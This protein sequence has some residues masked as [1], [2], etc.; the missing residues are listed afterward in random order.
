VNAHRLGVEEGE[1]QFGGALQ[2]HRR[3]TG[4][5]GEGQHA[6]G[7]ITRAVT[8]IGQRTGGERCAKSGQGERPALGLAGAAP[9]GAGLGERGLI[10]ALIHDE[11]GEIKRRPEREGRRGRF[12]HERRGAMG[13]QRLAQAGQERAGGGSVLKR[14]VGLSQIKKRCVEMHQRR[15][16][17]RGRGGDTGFRRRDSLAGAG[18]GP[19]DHGVGRAVAAG[20][21]HGA[22]QR[23]IAARIK[24][25]LRR[26][27]TIDAGDRHRLQP[28]GQNTRTH[29]RGR[30]AHG[31]SIQLIENRAKILGAG[32]EHRRLRGEPLAPPQGGRGHGLA[33]EQG[34]GE[35]SLGGGG[36]LKRRRERLGQSR[37][38]F[39]GVDLAVEISARQ[40][41]EGRRGARRPVGGNR[42]AGL[43][44]VERIRIG[45]Q[46]RAAFERDPLC[47]IGVGTGQTALD[48]GEA[49][50]GK[51]NRITVR[52]PR[53]GAVSRSFPNRTGESF[54]PNT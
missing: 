20:G 10:Q 8:V 44:C 51:R 48:H 2:R 11:A 6:R 40:R 30:L 37:Q 1:H 21:A 7:E 9:Q 33:I 39:G 47:D 17:R 41:R 32:C 36:V 45:G 34:C 22:G 14:A 26:A 16:H 43:A 12:K 19:L 18:D 13:P 54:R 52:I 28:L 29:R 24:A 15:L 42:G 5:S 23:A 27:V 31:R 50:H 25:F 38:R 3:R 46:H 35:F 53:A 4:L 49:P